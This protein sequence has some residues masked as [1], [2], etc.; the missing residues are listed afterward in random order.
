MSQEEIIFIFLD[1]GYYTCKEYPNEHHDK[2]VSWFPM[3]SDTRGVT[4]KLSAPTAIS[5]H[6]ERQKERCKGEGQ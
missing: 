1:A 2:L 4:Q 5:Q 3:E 6:L